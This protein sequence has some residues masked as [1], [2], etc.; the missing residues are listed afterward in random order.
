[1]TIHLLTE[2]LLAPRIRWAAVKFC[3]TK[4]AFHGMMGSR[5]LF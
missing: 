5:G 2:H 1:M 3:Q 4:P